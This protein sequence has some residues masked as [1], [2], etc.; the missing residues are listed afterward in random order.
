MYGHLHNWFD[1]LGMYVS[2]ELKLFPVTLTSWLAT[3]YLFFA[4]SK[5]TISK[6]N[7]YRQQH[8]I[9]RIHVKTDHFRCSTESI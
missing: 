9:S 5:L 8:Q 1:H 7:G 4:L 3:L 2:R 6:K